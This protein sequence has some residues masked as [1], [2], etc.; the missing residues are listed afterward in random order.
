MTS[1][2]ISWWIFKMWQYID[3]L[4]QVGIL[5][6]W[7]QSNLYTCIGGVRSYCCY[8][9]SV[10]YR[11]KIIILKVFFPLRLSCSK[12]K[13]WIFTTIYLQ[14]HETVAYKYFLAHLIRHVVLFFCSF[15]I[16]KSFI[17]KIISNCFSCFF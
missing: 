14:F 4:Y 12:N 7:K 9:L 2:W 11:V 3:L 16:V 17:L 15:F 6:H 8:V 1:K 13:Y 10:F 5:L